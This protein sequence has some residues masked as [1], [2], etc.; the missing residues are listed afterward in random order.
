[1]QLDPVL[2]RC[3]VR[4]LCGGAT[5]KSLRSHL[6]G[7]A[8]TRAKN[9]NPAMTAGTAEQI[10]SWSHCWRANRSGKEMTDAKEEETE[11]HG[12][13]TAN[14]QLVHLD[15]KFVSAANTP[16]SARTSGSWRCEP[17]ARIPFSC[18]KTTA[19]ETKLGSCDGVRKKTRQRGSRSTE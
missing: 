14:G 12:R 13:V 10:W 2:V 5:N 17:K 19:R 7:Y 18:Q 15:T 16:N 4:S 8:N 6:P 3:S 9:E 11:T 1:M